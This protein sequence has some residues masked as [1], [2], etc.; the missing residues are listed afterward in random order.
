[1]DHEPL[2]D[3]LEVELLLDHDTLRAVTDEAEVGLVVVQHIC[4]ALENTQADIDIQVNYEL[5]PC[6][7]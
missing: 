3:K 2:A 6:L 7:Y 5:N 4:D 1:M